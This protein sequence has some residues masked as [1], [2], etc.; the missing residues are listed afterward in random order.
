MGALARPRRRWEDSN[1]IDLTVL[2]WIQWQDGNE[3]AGSIK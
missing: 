3:P 2:D 1:K